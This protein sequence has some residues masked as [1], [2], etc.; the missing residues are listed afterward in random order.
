M[1]L[2][3]LLFLFM[4]SIVSLVIDPLFFHNFTEDKTNYFSLILQAGRQN[5]LLYEINLH[6]N[7]R[8]QDAELQEL[9]EKKDFDS[10]HAYSLN[11]ELQWNSGRSAWL[12]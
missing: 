9:R 5:F 6:K 12:C 10:D 11:A 1:L 8:R 7:S 2:F 4:L 3:F